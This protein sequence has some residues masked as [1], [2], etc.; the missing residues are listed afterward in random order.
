MSNNFDRMNA[1]VEAVGAAVLDVA[2]AIRNPAVDKN[3]QATIDALSTKLEAAA[4]ALA[5]ATAD[6]NAEDAGT[7]APVA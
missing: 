2:T 6:E 7:P 4:A 3:D 5:V 1:A